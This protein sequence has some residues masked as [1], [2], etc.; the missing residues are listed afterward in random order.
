[1]LYLWVFCFL[2][3]KHISLNYVEK[4][5]LLPKSLVWVTFNSAFLLNIILI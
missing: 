4:R 1:M 3:V 2:A 5:M